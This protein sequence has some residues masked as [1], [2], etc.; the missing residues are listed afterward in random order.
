MA[1][2]KLIEPNHIVFN[3][4]FAKHLRKNK[5]LNPTGYGWTMDQFEIVLMRLYDSFENGSFNKDTLSV[6][7]TC[8]ELGIP[9]TY[10]AIREYLRK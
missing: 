1:H 10:K 7:Q 2:L 3:K 8:E 5:V 6:Q 9:H 4:T